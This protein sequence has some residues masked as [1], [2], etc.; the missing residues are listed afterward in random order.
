M[1]AKLNKVKEWIKVIK[2]RKPLKQIWTIF[3]AKLRGHILGTAGSNGGGRRVIDLLYPLGSLNQ[4][5]FEQVLR[6]FLE[7]KANWH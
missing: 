1:R 2:D 5:D 3:V 7:K 4:K 6:L